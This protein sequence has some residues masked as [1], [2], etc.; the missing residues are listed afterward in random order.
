MSVNLSDKSESP[1]DV[2][3]FCR[4]L[5]KDHAKFGFKKPHMASSL[6]SKQLSSDIRWKEFP[7]L[8]GPYTLYPTTD[9]AYCEV[10]MCTACLGFDK[11]HRIRA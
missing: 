9:E 5:R 6:S 2:C 1:T 8:N 4:H 10:P 11:A 3:I 7:I